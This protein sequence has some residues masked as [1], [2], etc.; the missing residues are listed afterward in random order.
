MI[1][2]QDYIVPTIKVKTIEMEA[3]LAG[4]EEVASTSLSDEDEI[5]S[6]DEIEAKPNIGGYSWDDDDSE[7]YL[8]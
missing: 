2:T 3:I 7:E 6:S 1:K 8:W 4:S 5:N